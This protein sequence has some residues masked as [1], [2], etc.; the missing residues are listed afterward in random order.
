MSDLN[1]ELMDE[2]TVDDTSVDDLEN[3]LKEL[4]EESNSD[5]TLELEIEDSAQ[6]IDAADDNF[7]EDFSGFAKGF[8]G[9][10]LDPPSQSAQQAAAAKAAEIEMTAKFG[11]PDEKKTKTA[12][13]TKTTK[14]TKATKK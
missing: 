1:N 4:A 9:W 14:T 6:E 12:K 11:K 3:E 13:T 8:P 2:L 7:V 10:N 5:V